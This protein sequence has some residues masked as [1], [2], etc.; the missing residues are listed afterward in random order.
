MLDSLGSLL[1]V[2]TV[3]AITPILAAV[4]PGHVPQVVLL[5]LGG[6]L[7][8]PE[9]LDLADGAH[10]ELFANLGLGFLFLLAGY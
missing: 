6:I 10:I 9:A 5:I 2:V 8:G 7:I 4:L 1:G 3:A